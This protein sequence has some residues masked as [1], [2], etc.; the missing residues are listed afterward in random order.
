MLG[1]SL[2]PIAV[3]YSISLARPRDL[4]KLA[5]GRCVM[6]YRVPREVD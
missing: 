2:G 4:T 1:G 3:S 6:R 5:A